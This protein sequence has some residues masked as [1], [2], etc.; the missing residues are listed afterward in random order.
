M[1]TAKI[2]P[3]LRL[4]FPGS[5][6]NRVILGTFKARAQKN[7]FLREMKIN[8]RCISYDKYAEI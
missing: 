2:G 1:R 6:R 4:V 7:I 3:D 8:L 5:V